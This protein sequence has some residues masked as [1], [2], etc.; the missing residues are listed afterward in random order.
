LAIEVVVIEVAARRA[1]LCERDLDRRWWDFDDAEGAA[2]PTSAAP[3]LL[4]TPLLA[5]DFLPLWLQLKLKLKLKLNLWLWLKLKV[6]VYL[7]PLPGPAYQFASTSPH[8]S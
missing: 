2:C 5:P 7:R 1:A 8:S 3:L 4:Y 6:R